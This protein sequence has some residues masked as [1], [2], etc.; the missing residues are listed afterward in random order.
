[1]YTVYVQMSNVTQGGATVFPALG[2]SIFPVKGDAIFW[3]NL[4]PSGRGNHCMRHAACPVLTGSKWGTNFILV[5]LVFDI[6]VFYKV[7]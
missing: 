6:V 5:I 1:M 4:H 3:L 2:V 7:S